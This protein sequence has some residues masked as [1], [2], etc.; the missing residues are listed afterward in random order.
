MSWTPSHACFLRLRTP[1]CKDVGCG[2]GF[3]LE[4]AAARGFDVAGIDCNAA[5]VDWVKSS[6]GYPAFLGDVMD[7]EGDPRDVVTMLDVIEH[8]PQPLEA[9]E[10]AA[11]LTTPGGLLVVSTMDSDSLVSR[12]L[13]R[14]LEDFRRT[15]EHLYCF[16]RRTLRDVIERAGFDIVRIDSYGLTI[17]LG[18]LAK[19]A[20]L[21]FPRI[22]A[23]MAYG[24]RGLVSPTGALTS[25]RGPR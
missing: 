24:W 17:E 2:L 18:A 9:L 10:R 5:A 1:H 4:A 6:Y 21:A 7:Y 20:S 25:T 11:S 16:T 14:R 22:G 3:L 8:L 13:G 15:R 12:V 19:R 23:A